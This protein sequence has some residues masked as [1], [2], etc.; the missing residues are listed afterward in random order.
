MHIDAVNLHHPC[1]FRWL[2]SWWRGRSNRHINY[3]LCINVTDV[4]LA[5]R[6]TRI[7][8]LY[9]SSGPLDKQKCDGGQQK[10]NAPSGLTV[11]RGCC[12]VSHNRYQTQT[13]C[14]P[15]FWPRGSPEYKS[16]YTLVVFLFLPSYFCYY[17]AD[18][19][20]AAL[21]KCNWEHYQ[22]SHPALG[23]RA[24]FHSAVTHLFLDHCFKGFSLAFPLL[25]LWLAFSARCD[26]IWKR[27][28]HVISRAL[29]QVTRHVGHNTAYGH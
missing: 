16:L 24:Y 1:L 9:G 14:S 13:A 2:F 25:L 27:V 18:R 4:A 28:S 15:F 21:V 8:Q 12:D 26:H 29:D 11:A 19:V 3:K 5:F 20:W 10:L 6:D 22:S 23:K 7:T 17:G